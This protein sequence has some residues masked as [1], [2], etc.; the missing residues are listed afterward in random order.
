MAFAFQSLAKMVNP[1]AEFWCPPRRLNIAGE[2]AVTAGLRAVEPN[3]GVCTRELR[4][5]AARDGIPFH[6]YMTAEDSDFDA[7]WP[8]FETMLSTWRWWDTPA[9]AAPWNAIEGKGTELQLPK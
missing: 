2:V 8:E 5:K 3:S 9:D 7:R 6:A 4:V 1:S